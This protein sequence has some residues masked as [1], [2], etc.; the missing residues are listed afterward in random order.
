MDEQ[1]VALISAVPF[2][3]AILEEEIAKEIGR[4]KELKKKLGSDPFFSRKTIRRGPLDIRSGRFGSLPFVI[5]NSGVGK[6]NAAMTTTLLAQ[7][8]NPFLVI[9]FGVGGAYPG[10][11]LQP[12]DLALA[13]EE[14]FPDE[15]VMTSKGLFLPIEAMGYPL[16][17]T[18]EYPSSS[19][20][21][22]QAGRQKKLNSFPLDTDFLTEARKALRKSGIDFRTGTFLTVS[23]GTGTILQA[24][25]LR[26]KYGAICENMEGGA[27]A[28]VCYVFK[29]PLIEVRGISN[30]VENRD[31]RRWRVK[32]AAQ[33]VQQ[34]VLVML[35]SFARTLPLKS[36]IN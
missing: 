9:S 8:F 3:S 30:L 5:A 10:S 1:P 21:K 35:R 6:V 23:T 7:E 4:E 16:V 17:S 13:A 20:R 31:R 34:A 29:V 32:P 26:R 12:G 15:G 33:R 19:Q 18:R 11:K 14:I 36:I 24:R 28:Q 2:E 22:K 27:V 25:K